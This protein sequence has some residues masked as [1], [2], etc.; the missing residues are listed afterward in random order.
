MHEYLDKRYA[1]ALYEVSEENA[2]VEEYLEDLRQIAELMKTDE[3]FM[4]IIKHPKIS[5]SKKKKMF[6]DI[7]EKRINESL[8]SFL[9]LLIEKDRILFLEEIINE[10]NKIYLEK[11][12]KI[13]AEVKT[14]IPMLVKEKKS[15]INKLK[16]KYNKEIILKEELDESLIGGVYVKVGDDVI[17]GTIK[18]K[19]AE[20][21]KLMLKKE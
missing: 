1:L 16:A 13:T 5:T 19:I 18:L 9:L 4:E 6:T 14:V 10:L 20:M 15:L 11:N 7:F 12:N 17:D 3:Q 8:L 2:K 21:K